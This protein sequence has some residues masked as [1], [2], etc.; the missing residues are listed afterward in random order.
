[1][2]AVIIMSIILFSV[3]A[4]A[5]Q[6]R[7]TIVWGP[8]GESFCYDQQGSID[9]NL[10][11]SMGVKVDDR[12]PG[13]QVWNQAVYKFSS[14]SKTTQSKKLKTNYKTLRK[15][16][17]NF[18]AVLDTSARSAG[19]KFTGIARKQ[20][21]MAI[22]QTMKYRDKRRISKRKQKK[23][24]SEI[25]SLVERGLKNS[26]LDCQQILKDEV[27]R[28]S[29]KTLFGPI[30]SGAFGGAA[31]GAGAGAAALSL[32]PEFPAWLV[33]LLGTQ[34]YKLPLATIAPAAGVVALGVG[35]AIFLGYETVILSRLISKYKTYNT[36]KRAAE[37][38]VK[39]KLVKG[40]INKG[41]GYVKS[42]FRKMSESEQQNTIAAALQA[43]NRHGHC[44]N[45]KKPGKLWSNGDLQKFLVHNS[46]YIKTGKGP[47]SFHEIA[48][49]A[50]RVKIKIDGCP[51][52]GGDI[53]VEDLIIDERA[54]VNPEGDKH[55]GSITVR[56]RNS[57]IGDSTSKSILNCLK[58]MPQ[59]AK[60]ELHTISRSGSSDRRGRVI[61]INT[62]AQTGHARRNPKKDK[63]LKILFKS[64]DVKEQNGGTYTADEMLVVLGFRVE[65]G[66]AGSGSDP[67]SAWETCSAS[68]TNVDTNLEHD[69][70]LTQINNRFP[71]LYA[72]K[73]IMAISDKA[74]ADLK[75]WKR[76]VTVK[77]INEDGTE[78]QTYTYQSCFAKNY[79]MLVPHP[80]VKGNLYEDVVIKK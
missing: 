11:N 36:F 57:K 53:T 54:M 63:G 40:Y 76:T 22:F 7:G 16:L 17:I 65:V 77:S 37:G 3:Q 79:E 39:R 78:G 59:G 50:T 75:K 8:E 15:A 25:F 60:M 38:K 9:D 46:D 70:T 23:L 52:N 42:S 74:R 33:S 67:D 24:F 1:M 44:I 35:V 58:K 66:G 34:I 64:I 43:M 28:L 14:V 4:Y 51:I 21:K 12:D 48:T 31:V 45:L 13:S 18:Y 47:H 49:A 19:K 56:A 32:G 30:F 62:A 27:K 73:K 55:Y 6:C 61:T 2:K 80:I 69:Q 41:K 72:G 10:L 5:G 20:L 68:R 29:K 26:K 71:Q